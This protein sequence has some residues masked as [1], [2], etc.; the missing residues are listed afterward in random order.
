VAVTRMEG[1]PGRHHRHPG[2]SSHLISKHAPQRSPSS[3]SAVL[4]AALFTPYPWLY[5]LPYPQ[6]PP[7]V[8]RVFLSFHQ[9]DDVSFVCMY[10]YV[11][12]YPWMD[13][14]THGARSV[15][16]AVERGVRALPAAAAAADI[17]A[18]NAGG[19]GGERHRRGHHQQKQRQKRRRHCRHHT[20]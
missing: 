3:N 20:P 9:P 7:A 1:L 15:A 8:P 19:G 4:S 13:V 18:G 12:M 17:H 5:R 16:A 2:C 6:A 14:R 11:C 10:M